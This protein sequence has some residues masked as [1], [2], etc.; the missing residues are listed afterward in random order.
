MTDNLMFWALMF[1]II[2]AL[3]TCAVGLHIRIMKREQISNEKLDAFEKSIGK[4]LALHDTRLSKV[5]AACMY[6]PTHK[7]LE[8]IYDRINGVSEQVNKLVGGVQ[9]LDNT[10]DILHQYLMNEKN[11]G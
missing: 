2:H 4:R 7:D 3:I 11:G 8:K 6:G 5:E 9:A 1:Q 10:V